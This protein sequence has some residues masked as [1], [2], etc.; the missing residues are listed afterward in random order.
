MPMPPHA[1][2]K[3]IISDASADVLAY[4]WSVECQFRLESHDHC[5]NPSGSASR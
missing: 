4:V 1:A 5:D 3:C 2:V